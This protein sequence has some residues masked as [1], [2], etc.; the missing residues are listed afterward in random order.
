MSDQWATVSKSY[1]EELLKDS[2]LAPILKLKNKP[3]AFPNGV[4]IK[5]RIK[6]LDAA[7]PN[8]MEAKR[9]LQ[10]K[11]FNYANIDDDVPVFAF[12]G[13]VT[14]QKGVHLILDVA[15]EIIKKYNYKV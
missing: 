11:Y 4:P 5:E 1:K 8:H 2:P 3:F 13:R 6:K 10:Q 12:V 14:D 7:A 15:E 9:M